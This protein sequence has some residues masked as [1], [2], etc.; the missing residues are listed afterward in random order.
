MD[1]DVLGVVPTVRCATKFGL[2]DYERH[3]QNLKDVEL[4]LV[5]VSSIRLFIDGQ[6]HQRPSAVHKDS[7]RKNSDLNRRVKAAATV[8]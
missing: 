4:V 1:D 5:E 3:M 6:P 7:W 8:Q 2:L